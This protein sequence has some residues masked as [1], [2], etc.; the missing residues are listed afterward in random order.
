MFSVKYDIVEETYRC[1]G[2]VRTSYGIAAYDAQNGVTEVLAALHD[3]SVNEQEI[4]TLVDKCNELSLSLEHF[5]DV[6]VDF[7]SK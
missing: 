2:T 6:V 7:L 4:C 5:E 1:D 3:I